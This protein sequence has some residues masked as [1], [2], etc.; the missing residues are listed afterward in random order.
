VKTYD[1]YTFGAHPD[2]IVGWHKFESEDDEAAMA[3]AAAMVVHG[4]SELW[5]NAVL[6]KRWEQDSEMKCPLWVESGHK[7][8][9]T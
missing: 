8:S 1:L 7:P 9:P 3:L 6:V 5:H 4:P 2:V